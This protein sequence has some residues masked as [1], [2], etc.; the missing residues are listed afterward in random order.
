VDVRPYV[1]WFIDPARRSLTILV[2]WTGTSERRPREVTVGPTF[3]VI[4]AL[5]EIE[6]RFGPER[7][8]HVMVLPFIDGQLQPAEF[9]RSVMR[10]AWIA[11]GVVR[12]PSGWLRESLKVLAALPPD[13]GLA[14]RRIG[15]MRRRPTAESAP[16]PRSRQ[17]P[18]QRSR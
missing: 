15:Q 1:C 13:Y 7:F 16:G 8:P 11:T 14:E 18:R 3:E 4:K 5:G 12:K 9:W 10:E 2:L 17:K 6:R